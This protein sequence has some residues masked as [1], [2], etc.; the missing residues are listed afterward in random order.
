MRKWI[1]KPKLNSRQIFFRYSGHR[2]EL[3][4][5]CI[6]PL[7]SPIVQGRQNMIVLRGVSCIRTS[8]ESMDGQGHPAIWCEFKLRNILLRWGRIGE[9]CVI[10]LRTLPTIDAVCSHVSC[11]KWF[12]FIQST[13]TVDATYSIYLMNIK[14]MHKFKLFGWSSINSNRCLVVGI[15]LNSQGAHSDIIAC[16]VVECRVRLTSFEINTWKL[17]L[18]FRTHTISSSWSFPTHTARTLVHNVNT[19]LLLLRRPMP[20]NQVDQS[21][22]NWTSQPQQRTHGAPALHVHTEAFVGV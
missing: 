8:K 2:N 6:S 21:D 7:T 5:L 16:S 17:R 22:R 9:M 15:Q 18:N 20:S 4:A 13:S 12:R 19:H 10:L 11:A 1:Y 14:R 3:L